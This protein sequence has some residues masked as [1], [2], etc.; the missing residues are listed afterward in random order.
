MGINNGTHFTEQLKRF[1]IFSKNSQISSKIV[2]LN[3]LNL[4][5]ESNFFRFPLTAEN[6]ILKRHYWL[7][8]L[9]DNFEVLQ[10]KKL[11]ELRP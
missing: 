2:R 3:H 7:F 4:F 6:V 11:L 1:H 8:L 5:H 10:F 9:H